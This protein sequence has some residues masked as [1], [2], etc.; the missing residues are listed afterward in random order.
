[1]QTLV[2]NL[3]FAT[4]LALCGCRDHGGR[5]ESQPII[6][7]VASVPAG[8]A[9][10]PSP[11]DAAVPLRVPADASRASSTPSNTDGANDAASTPPS[12][13][14]AFVVPATGPCPEFAP[15]SAVFTPDGH[16]REV[17]L[18]IGEAARDLDGPLIFAWHATSGTPAQTLTWIGSDVLAE[19]EAQGG[20]VV[21]PHADQPSTTRPWYYTPLGPGDEDLDLRLMDEVVACAR[22]HVGIDVR[23]I[24]ALGMS[25]GGLQTTQ[26]AFRRS[27]YLAS[28]V[29]YS[30]GL[31]DERVPPRQAPEPRLAAMILYGGPTDIS[32]VDGIRFADATARLVGSLRSGDHFVVLCNHGAGHTVPVSAQRSAWQFLADHPFGVVPLPYAN[33]LPSGFATFCTVE[34]DSSID[35]GTDLDAG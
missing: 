22:E 33:G 31:P 4:A 27:G 26:I 34:R 15:G 21:A 9:M 35:A 1:M 8:E 7:H 30:G 12:A 10:L 29:I 23:R 24:H 20:I 18:S 28:V 14:E 2:P 17:E 3:I 25:A 32:P 19:I 6:T 5:D 11:M 13:P 16:A